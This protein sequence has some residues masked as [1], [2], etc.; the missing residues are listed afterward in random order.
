MTD[1]KRAYQTQHEKHRTR[2]LRDGNPY[3]ELCS[4]RVRLFQAGRKGNRR[5]QNG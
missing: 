2:R 4:C 3:R 5:R 1:K